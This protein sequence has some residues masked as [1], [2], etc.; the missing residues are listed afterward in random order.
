MKIV[1]WISIEISELDMYIYTLGKQIIRKTNVIK[2]DKKKYNIRND[3]D[4]VEDY[5][6]RKVA[7]LL[8][9]ISPNPYNTLSE[10]ISRKI[11]ASMLIE[12]NNTADFSGLTDEKF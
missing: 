3:K 12:T 2:S 1:I 9:K 5:V 4:I 7:T 6:Y 10:I 11:I 8:A